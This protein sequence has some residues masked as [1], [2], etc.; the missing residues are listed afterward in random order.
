MIRVS[1]LYVASLC[2]VRGLCCLEFGC[3]KLDDDDDGLTLNTK[4]LSKRKTN[5]HKKRPFCYCQRR[6]G[7]ESKKQTKKKI[8]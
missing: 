5:Y 2:C 4:I 8:A 1:M 6:Q 3:A 7:I